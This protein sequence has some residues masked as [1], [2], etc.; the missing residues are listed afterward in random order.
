MKTRLTLLL[1][2]TAGT[3]SYAQNFG[4][5]VSYAVTN[6]EG[7]VYDLD[8]QTETLNRISF[9]IYGSAPLS[10][11]IALEPGLFLTPKGIKITQGPFSEPTSN[12]SLY[13]DVPLLLKIY[14]GGGGFNVSAGPQFS[15]LL[16]NK[17]VSDS[18]GELENTD[19]LVR[20]D[21]AA[22]IGLAYDFRFGLNIGAQFD[23]GGTNMI[24]DGEDFP[25]Y[26]WTEARNRVLRFSL[27][28]TFGTM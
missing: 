6:W 22:V 20:W 3:F 25:Y 28:Y 12:N 2:I 26:E 7:L 17:L 14:I 21:V 19:Q 10:A 27:G 16:S 1:L 9:G 24:I 8:M 11:S 18:G 23:L 15:Y 4:I 13:L 5:K